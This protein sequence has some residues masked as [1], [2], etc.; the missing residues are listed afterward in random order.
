MGI[1][2]RLLGKRN[3]IIKDYYNA[4]CFISIVG[5]NTGLPKDTHKILVYLPT[6]ITNTKPQVNAYIKDLSRMGFPCKYLGIKS[7]TRNSQIYKDNKLVDNFIT[8]KYYCITVPIQ[9]KKG[10]IYKSKDHWFCTLTLIRYLLEYSYVINKYFA[11]CKAVG[12][13]VNKFKALQIANHHWIGSG[14]QIFHY[15]G[16]G[17]RFFK[18]KTISEVRNSFNTDKKG[19]FS[20][21]NSNLFKHFTY[22]PVNVNNNLIQD[23][24]A[25]YHAILKKEYMKTNVYVVG[26]QRNYANWLPDIKLVD[27]V[28]DSDVVLFTGGEDVHPSFYGEPMGEHTSSNIERDNREK[29]I[30]DEAK[31]LGKKFLGICRG[32]QFLCVMAGGKLVQHQNNPNYEHKILTDTRQELNITSTHHQAQ[33]PYNLPRYMYKILAWTNDQSEFHLDGNGVELNPEKECEIVYYNNIYGL[34]IQGHPEHLEYQRNPDNEASLEYLK[35]LFT[36]YLAKK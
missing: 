13:R 26:G 16:G 21:E 12:K 8:D 9:N 4:A 24:K 25:L 10:L 3:K 30:F 36:S 35:K 29:E 19:T 18:L 7:V 28:K 1:N 27:N 15:S 31:A 2:Y 32:S 22:K 6:G 5:Y 20:T 11:I 17:Q 14:H 23:P 34:A 33:Y